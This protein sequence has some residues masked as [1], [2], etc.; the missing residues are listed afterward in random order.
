VV[1]IDGQ[2]LEIGDTETDFS[3]QSSC[4]PFNYCFALDDLGAEKVHQHIGMEPSGQAF[5]ARELATAEATLANNGIC[6]AT[7]ERVF[8]ESTERNCLT[9]MQKCGMYDGSGEFS[10][11]IG[12]PAKSGV[13]GAVILV[14]PRLM[15]ICIWSPRLDPIGNSVRGVNMAKR[16]THTYRLHVYD[17]MA[18]RSDRID[19]RVAAARLRARQASQMLRATSIGDLRALRHLLEDQADLS[20]GDYDRRAPLHLAAA[21][22]HLEIVRFLLENGVRPNL[23]DRW[24]GT[25]LNHAELGAHLDVVD[26]L[27]RHGAEAG[28]AATSH[29]RIHTH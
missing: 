21:E 19:P 8:Q 12:L 6:P 14:V 3:V 24:G 17:G 22:G 23:H 9:L 7:K 2:L 16:L 4:K 25:P 1:S 11:H 26:L 18:E 15:G 13:G 20:K 10:V 5:N 27:K 29:L 28:G